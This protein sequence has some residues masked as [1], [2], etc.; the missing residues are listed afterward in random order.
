MITIENATCLCQYR[1][2]GRKYCK[3]CANG[4]AHGPYYYL[5]KRYNN[6]IFS[7]YIGLKKPIDMQPYYERL[8]AKI[9][10]VMQQQKALCNLQFIAHE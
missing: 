2:C 10:R 8:A 6:Q 4:G 9:E 3:T 7:L 5:Y 1:K